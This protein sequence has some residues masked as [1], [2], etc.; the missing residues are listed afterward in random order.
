MSCTNA[1]GDLI[2]YR[3]EIRPQGFRRGR[4]CDRD[5]CGEQ[6][7]LDRGG[8]FFFPHEAADVHNKV[9]HDVAPLLE[10]E[11]GAWLAS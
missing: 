9:F 4:D 7:V 1:A 5:E 10:I 3:V 2:E 6:T 8:A 11:N